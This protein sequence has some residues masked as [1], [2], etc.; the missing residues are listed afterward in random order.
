MREHK[1]NLDD[2]TLDEIESIELVGEEDTIDITVED[3]HMFYANDIYTHNSSIKAEVV[4]ADQ[5]AGSIKKG[6]IGHFIVSVAKSMPQKENNT[7]TLAVLKSRFGKDGITFTD[8]T[9]NNATIQ[10]DISEKN[11]AQTFMQ[12][13]DVQEIN[14]QVMINAVLDEANKRRQAR[15]EKKELEG[16]YTTVEN[17]IDSEDADTEASN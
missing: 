3:T 5:M 15:L 8:C 17:N 1:L 6:M 14:Q 13:H 4:E 7:A 11:D 12:R 16:V 9:F 2:F 10:I